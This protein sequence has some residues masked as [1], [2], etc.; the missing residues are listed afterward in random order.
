MNLWVFSNHRYVLTS[1][2]QAPNPPH[3]AEWELL[4]SILNGRTTFNIQMACK[5]CKDNDAA[6]SAETEGKM[7]SCA[8]G[9]EYCDHAEFGP[10]IQSLCPKTCKQCDTRSPTVPPTKPPSPRPT[11]TPTRAPSRD[12]THMCTSIYA[13]TSDPAIAGIYHLKLRSHISVWERRGDPNTKIIQ[14]SR[15]TRRFTIGSPLGTTYYHTSEGQDPESGTWMYMSGSITRSSLSITMV[16]DDTQF[17]SQSPTKPSPTSFS[18]ALTEA[19]S[20]QKMTGSKMTQTSQEATSSRWNF[21]PETYSPGLDAVVLAAALLGCC[22]LFYCRSQD[23]IG[24]D[25]FLTG[26]ERAETKMTQPIVM[27]LEME[28]RNSGQVKPASARQFSRFSATAQEGPRERKKNRKA[29]APDVAATEWDVLQDKQGRTYYLNTRTRE[30]TWSRPPELS[31]DMKQD[32]AGDDEYAD[33][34]T[35]GTP[36]SGIDRGDQYQNDSS[37][38]SSGGSDSDEVTASSDQHDDGPGVKC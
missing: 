15:E 18:E 35:E 10:V 27:E 31:A 19:D 8:A 37:T 21:N 7:Q 11:V 29:A 13:T 22:V 25:R 30:T 6:L 20:H 14:D 24:L 28:D 32:T 2:F 33:F 36:G 26:R 23:S 17:P 12:P 3:Q 4:Q 5:A 34:H 9:A 38:N 1:N 16:C